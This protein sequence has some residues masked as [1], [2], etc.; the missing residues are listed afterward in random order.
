MASRAAEV[1]GET[2]AL[3]V[4]G[5]ADSVQRGSTGAEIG[6]ER[7]QAVTDRLSPEVK[8][9]ADRIVRDRTSR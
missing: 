4:L 6:R 8:A 1:Q 7:I 5:I 2:A 9:V 3:Q